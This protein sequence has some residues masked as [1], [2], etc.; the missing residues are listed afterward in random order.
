MLSKVVFI[1]MVVGIREIL[2]SALH[3]RA[4]N[5]YPHVYP[6][7]NLQ[8]LVLSSNTLNLVS[9]VMKL[10]LKWHSCGPNK[11]IFNTFAGKPCSKAC[12]R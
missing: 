12:K 4:W 7:I 3:P 6:E 11:S 5:T 9:I 8:C 10:F 1:R 2:D